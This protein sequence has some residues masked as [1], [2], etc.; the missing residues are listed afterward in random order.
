[1]EFKCGRIFNDYIDFNTQQRALNSADPTKKDFFKLMNNAT[2]G[3]TIENVMKRKDF[4]LVTDE[5][6][7]RK[8]AEKPNCSRWHVFEDDKLIGIEMSKKNVVINKPFHVSH[9]VV[10]YLKRL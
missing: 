5:V 10:S 8:L 4:H 3:K 2:Y 9:C 1:M 7:A 6:K